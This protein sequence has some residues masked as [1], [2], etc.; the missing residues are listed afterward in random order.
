M[1]YYDGCA[2]HAS[3]CGTGFVPT[4]HV[5]MVPTASA[6][7]H[8][9]IEAWGRPIYRKK[10][11]LGKWKYAGMSNVK[12]VPRTHVE[13]VASF[14]PVQHIDYAPAH[15][16]YCAPHVD[17]C[18]PPTAHVDYCAPAHVDYCA[19]ATAHVDY[20]APGGYDAH[21]A[22]GFATGH[23]DYCAP[24]GYD[25][26]CAPGGFG[27]FDAHCAPGYGGQCY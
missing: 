12:Y 6:A 20:C 15:V 25:A 17:Y 22:P 1:A 26:H 14:A 11:L 9:L 4:A 23:V 13:P 8:T 19:P 21:C 16:D 2:P 7:P 18:A 10:W 24:G 3:V 5:D 27:G